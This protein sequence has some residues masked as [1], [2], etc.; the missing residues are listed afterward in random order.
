MS[1]PYK[2]PA[3]DPKPGRSILRAPS[4]AKISYGGR[5]Q[6]TFSLGT[7]WP[8]Q[9]LFRKRNAIHGIL[10][11]DLTSEVR[12]PLRCYCYCAPPTPLLLAASS[13][14]RC[15]RRLV[16]ASAAARTSS[17]RARPQRQTL[18]Q[19]HLVEEELEE[20]EEELAV[21]RAS[22]NQAH[23]FMDRAVFPELNLSEDVLQGDE[24]AV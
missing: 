18:R 4:S 15:Q 17:A 2:E 5:R 13:P 22:L 20:L 14:S 8:C 6:V 12:R 7:V 16:A 9:V 10:P 3:H 24:P 23:R 11:L 19:E 1:P 21:V